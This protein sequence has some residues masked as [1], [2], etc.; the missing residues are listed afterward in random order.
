MIQQLPSKKAINQK[1]VEFDSADESSE[2]ESE[3]GEDEFDSGDITKKLKANVDE[4]F[5]VDSELR[6]YARYYI[7]EK[8]IIRNRKDN[9]LIEKLEKASK[10]KIKKL[11]KLGK[12]HRSVYILAF[13]GT[14]PLNERKIYTGKQDETR[15]PLQKPSEYIYSLRKINTNKKTFHKKHSKT[16][17]E[18]IVKC[19]KKL[20][21]GIEFHIIRLEKISPTGIEGFTNSDLDPIQVNI[22]SHILPSFRQFNS[23]VVKEY[24]H[25]LLSPENAREHRV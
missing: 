4:D 19:M 9:K 6:A 16:M 8:L 1:E 13:K 15:N 11:N 7:Y 3:S 17:Y 10:K 14:E 5:N 23:K 24:V 21:R 22:E 20:K 25:S 2:D 12:L 18:H